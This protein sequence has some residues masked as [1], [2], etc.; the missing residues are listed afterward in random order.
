MPYETYKKDGNK[1]CVRKS[2]SK[3]HVGCSDKYHIG[4]YLA[5]LDS[6]LAKICFQ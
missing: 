1:Y 3:E 2:D 5:K 4:G 6:K